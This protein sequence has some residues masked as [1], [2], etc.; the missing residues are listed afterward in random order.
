MKTFWVVAALLTASSASLYAQSLSDL[1]IEFHGY[2]T[3]GF[4]Y[5]NQNNWD[6]TSSTNGS[7]AWTDAVVNLTAQPE[8]KLRIGVQGRYFLLGNYGNS[9]TL[10]WAAADYK[11]DSRFGV[12][13]GKVK[14]PTGL[15]NELQDIDPAV[16]WALLPQS[17][18][19]L[20]RR[21]SVLAHY[22]GVV[23]GELEMGKK[24]GSVE[25]RAFGGERVLSGTNG[26]FQ[27]FLDEGITIP[28]GTH[29]TIYGGALHWKAP[30]Q[31][32]MLGASEMVQHCDP[33]PVTVPLPVG[34]GGMIVAVPGN[35]AL[36]PT[37]TPNLFGKY[38]KKAIMVAGEYGRIP[39]PASINLPA[40]PLNINVS[41]DFHNWYMMS[42]YRFNDHLTAG[43]YY[44][45]AE[46]HQAP[47]G[48]GRYQKD[49]AVS[50]RY[51][52]NPYMYAKAEQ[53]FMD[54]TETGFSILTNAGGLKATTRMTVLK[55]GVTF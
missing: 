24:L 18:Y 49:W 14:T 17:V 23:Y 36:S 22:G 11:V 6:T 1:N 33:T 7:P 53:H 31:G 48:Q 2:A 41:V 26:Y 40:V 5:T 39:L 30:V 4:V 20:A 12:R 13:F 19:P 45:S 50:G 21:D 34:P 16:S 9:I 46:N 3:Q 51:Y 15:F 38:E 27:P 37:N 35:A 47:L 28:N 52:F 44:S 29:A 43:A 32:L 10:D 42:N 55:I 25:Y 54:G 8:S